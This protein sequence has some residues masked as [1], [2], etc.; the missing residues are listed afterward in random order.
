MSIT[1]LDAHPI[2]MEVAVTD[3]LAIVKKV[4]W[5][6]TIY[7]FVTSKTIQAST[8]AALLGVLWPPAGVWLAANPEALPALFV[9][10]RLVTKDP[11]VVK[12]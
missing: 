11:I 8:V 2:Q 7:N 12:A 5:K 10:L 4:D 9:V 1:F 6:G 3:V